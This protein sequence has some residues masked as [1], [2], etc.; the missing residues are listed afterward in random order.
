MVW[1]LVFCLAFVGVA[2]KAFQQRN[3]VFENWFSIVPVSYILAS[4]E[5][6]TTGV[7]AVEFVKHGPLSAPWLILAMG[8][9]GW[10]GCFFAI[11]LH[12]RIHRHE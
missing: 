6:L 9:G 8:T 4:M 12:K 3:N 11:Y 7:I 5:V 10:F 1:L 2:A